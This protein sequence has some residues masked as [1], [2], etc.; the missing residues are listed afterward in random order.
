[1][2]L[3]SN[4]FGSKIS[5]LINNFFNIMFITKCDICKKE[6]KDTKNKITAGAGNLLIGFSFCENC[7]QPVLRFLVKHGL[8]EKAL[9]S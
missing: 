3:M 8:A 2:G 4:L 6:I 5:F 1:M 7:G 9:K